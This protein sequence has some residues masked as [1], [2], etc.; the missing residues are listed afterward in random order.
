MSVW[1]VRLLRGLGWIAWCASIGAVLAVV[2]VQVLPG[3]SVGQ[4]FF[5]DERI[6][7]CMRSSLAMGLAATI[8]ALII[9]LPTSVALSITPRGRIRS[10]LMCLTILPLVTMPSIFGYAWMLLA[11]SHLPLIAKVMGFIGWNRPGGVVLQS[12]F[13]LAT[14][15]WPVP[16]L[17]LS[18]AFQQ[19][20]RGAYQL[21]LL[22]ATP[23]RA[24]MRGTLPELIAPG[25]AASIV[26]F[27]LALLDP[28]I[29]PLLNATQVWSVEMMAQAAAAAKQARP[30][31]HLFWMAWPMLALIAVGVLVALP[32]M[33]QL[34]MAAEADESQTS[35]ELRINSRRLT[36]LAL[37]TAAAFSL[38]PFVVFC[39][40][41]WSGRTSTASALHSAARTLE[42]DG[43]ASLMTATIT[44]VCC[45]CIALAV[46]D[47]PNWPRWRRSLSVA[48]FV[49]VLIL[50]VMPPELIGTALIW[51]FGRCDP[52]RWNFYDDSP[53][54]WA[55]AI[56]CRFTFIPVCAARILSRRWGREI[57]AMAQTDGADRMQRLTHAR[58][59]QIAR[60]LVASASLVLLMA[61]SEVAV[62]VLVQPVRFF[63]GSLAVQID[64]QMHYGRQNQTIAMAMLMVIPALVA[65]I[66]TQ[67][68]LGKRVSP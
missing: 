32:G 45:A 2:I 48:V 10:G 29:P 66:I 65:V 35:G 51:L 13:V 43:L 31:G 19:T 49:G 7:R 20:G 36:I 50:A 23:V 53:I 42:K 6:L 59:P 34:S 52:R 9:A 64:S 21:A 54:V 47:E 17:T 18:I 12:G 11:T 4:R 1:F 38:L 30:V 3:P 68:G 56:A 37:C 27:L 28:T 24:L 5:P 14:W 61:L 60:V 25:I 63:G 8:I 67:L 58:L 62:S 41:L 46:L 40:E 15:L 57:D 22:D 16:A 26:V 33:R 44:A 39:I 55:G